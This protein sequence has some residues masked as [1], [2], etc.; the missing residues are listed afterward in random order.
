MPR[1]LSG[2]AL[3][4]ALFATVLAVFWP[5]LTGPFLFDD[6]PTLVDNLKLHAS[7]LELEQ[8]KRAAFSFEPADGGRAL[9]M[10]SFAL[11]HVYGGL[12]P[13]SYKL[14][15]VVVHALN[16]ILVYFL[17]ARL[18]VLANLPATHI[19]R[20][21]LLLATLWAVHPL[22][23]SSALYVV[24]RMETLATFFV[25]LALLSYTLGRQLQI[26]GQR[27]W[28]WLLTCIPLLALGLTSKETPA[29][30]PAYTLTL[31]LCLLH[32]SA[33]RPSTARN[34]RWLYALATAAGVLLFIFVIVPHYG[35]SETVTGRNFSTAER[36]LSQLRILPLYLQQILLPLPSNMYFYYDDFAP[37]RGWLSPATTLAGAAF[38]LGLLLAAWQLRKR[39]PLFALGVA[40]FFAAHFMTSNVIA[41][42]LV[43]EHRNYFALFGVLL[44][45]TGLFQLLPEASEAKLKPIVLVSLLL[46]VAFL[47]VLRSASWGDPL[48]LAVQHTSYNPQSA[49]AAHELGVLYYD[50]ADG[51]TGSPFFQFAQ[52]QF[53]RESALPH[54]SILGDQALI[55]L[56]AAL[57]NVGK[58]PDSTPHWDALI[59]K[60]ETRPITPETT[61]AMFAL[62]ENRYQDKFIDDARLTEAFLTMFDKVMLPP[63]SYAQLADHVWKHQQD[64]AL[65]NHV[66]QMAVEASRDTPDYIQHLVQQL[67]KDERA[68]QAQLVLE[69]AKLAGIAH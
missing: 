67:R 5:G 45:L 43:F 64:E 54:A 50:M 49:R 65:S 36:V 29:L 10:L 39:L 3:P 34:W 15:G 6:F 9:A 16:A 13:W 25:L 17:A 69:T 41:L 22:Q 1:L 55:L 51:Y 20:L 66:L 60:L 68:E 33:A 31:E 30:F 62:L 27:G 26:Q 40:W 23:V 57:T 59:D 44:A 37:S 28:P 35:S 47:T 61:Q 53:A 4:L 58:A 2:F 7:A 48:L 8:L 12:D 56:D 46:C 52:Q 42:E 63:Y 18:L 38:L 19:K 14:A 32:F 11:N 24:Q 21:A